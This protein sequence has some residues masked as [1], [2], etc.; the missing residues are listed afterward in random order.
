MFNLISIYVC[1][2]SGRFSVEHILNQEEFA[3]P[4]NLNDFHHIN[5][6]HH[7]LTTLSKMI[8]LFSICFIHSIHRYFLIRIHTCIYVFICT[9]V[10]VQL[11]SYIQRFVTPWTVAC[12]APFSLHGIVQARMLEWAAISSFRRSSQQEQNPRLLHWQADS[13]S[14]SHLG[15]LCM[16]Y[17]Y[18]YDHHPLLPEMK[19]HE[20]S[21][22]LVFQHYN[23]QC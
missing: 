9:V 17:F 4:I 20:S 14:P 11:L 21:S 8:P 5:N 13:L 22:G 7:V 18:L 2:T 19:L 3:L 16:Y 1:S 23:T 15:S 12:K 6:D 10:V